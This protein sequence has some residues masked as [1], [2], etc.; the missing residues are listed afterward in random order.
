MNLENTIN[1][2]A[3]KELRIGDHIRSEK[4]GVFQKVIKLEISPYCEDSLRITLEQKNEWGMGRGAN[5]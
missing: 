2:L 3:V 4:M 1:E 5:R